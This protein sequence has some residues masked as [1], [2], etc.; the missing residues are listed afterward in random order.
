VKTFELGYGVNLKAA[1]EATE[2]AWQ[3]ATHG[4]RPIEQFAPS[5]EGRE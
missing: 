5:V 3:L 2:M 4:V 1:A